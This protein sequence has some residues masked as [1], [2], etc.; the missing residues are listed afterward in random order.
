MLIQW[1]CVYTTRMTSRK[2]CHIFKY[3]LTI[4]QIIC[5][6]PVDRIESAA[7]LIGT[8]PYKGNVDNSHVV[9]MEISWQTSPKPLCPIA[10]SWIHVCVCFLFVF[11]LS[12]L[13]SVHNSHWD[14]NV[15]VYQWH[16]FIYGHEGSCLTTRAV[17]TS[18]ITS[19]LALKPNA[20]FIFMRWFYSEYFYCL[21][22]RPQSP[23]EVQMFHFVLLMKWSIT[24]LVGVTLTFAWK[25][26]RRMWTDIV[27]IYI[28]ITH[29]VSL[30][31][32]GWWISDW[33]HGLRRQ[34]TN[35]NILCSVLSIALPVVQER[36]LLY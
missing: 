11:F 18:M 16:N 22:M 23:S 24:V 21:R 3:E 30:F 35:I 27:L 31:V 12:F 4:W 34:H 8:W 10:E 25:A 6:V 28:T 17:K 13:L 20:C 7:Y 1:V 26:F 19:L 29:Q 9:K 2:Y 15:L 32:L 5:V 36:H 14:L 33:W